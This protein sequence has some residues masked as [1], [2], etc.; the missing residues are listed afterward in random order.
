MPQFIQN[1]IFFYATLV[2]V[3]FLP[4]YF[5]LWA[6]FGRQKRF[7]RLE[8]FIISFGLSIL[9]VDFLML[10]LN[11]IKIPLTRLSLMISITIFIGICYG[12]Y[13]KF[14]TKNVGKTCRE[15][16]FSLR[17][18]RL[19]ILL[20]ILTV[21]IKAAYLQYNTL[22]ATT[23]LGHHMY[24]SKVISETGSIPNYEARDIVQ[25]GGN[26]AIS[27]PMPISDFIVGEHLI[28]SATN[29]ISGIDFISYF[30]VIILYLINLMSVLALF[31]LALK[32]F[33]DHPQGKNIAILALFFLGPLFAVAPPQ[34]KYVGGGVIGNLIGN[35]LLPLAFYFYY[36]A[37]KGKDRLSLAIALIFSMGLFYTHH[38]T[39]LLFLL[40]F[41]LS[42]IAIIVVHFR[43]MSLFLK[44]W[45]KIIFS[46]AVL[47]VLIFAVV[48]VF[49]VYTPTYLVNNAVSTIVGGLAK[50][51]H[52][53]LAFSEFKFTVGEPRVAIGIIGIIAF[54][55]LLRPT[56]KTKN[57]GI[58]FLFA[59]TFF[60]MLI[61]LEPA[62]LDLS[63]PSARIANYGAFPL[64]V[65]AA[66]AIVQILNWTKTAN[67]LFLVN[68]KLFLPAFILLA[69]FAVTSGFYDNS[70]Y[71]TRSVNAQKT[72]QTFNASRYLAKKSSAADQILTDHIYIASD[73][74][75]KLFFMRG[76]NF[77][78]YRAN[79]D[80]YSNGIDKQ[81]QCTLWMIS[82]PAAPDSQ[83]CYNDLGID[84]VMANKNFDG[85]QFDK[86]PDFSKI[87]SNGE[88]NIYYRPTNL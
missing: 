74:W 5:F 77:P 54:L 53:G 67:R 36:R 19:I 82:T 40:A 61:S 3:L 17:Q 27:Q 16:D 56:Y 9:A 49:F 1:Q 73:S 71:S 31:L 57:Y 13:K 51:E 63:I 60:I 75:I 23:D 8:E 55:L 10:F 41:A 4:G 70:Q 86:S 30:P 48:F 50:I 43:E 78:L 62:W 34:A 72:I 83:K 87:Y 47:A 25:S 32:L 59:W 39:G 76:Y 2:F 24:W 65:I 14:Q 12:I 88:L 11:R 18:T 68:H 42:L 66:F 80:R 45:M 6:A 58:I 33:E 44:T 85:S 29:L 35:L 20:L 81:E 37:F 64:S 69:A 79:L 52:Q 38:L 84:F 22:P 26:Y 7:N 21:F 15:F 28:F 46:P